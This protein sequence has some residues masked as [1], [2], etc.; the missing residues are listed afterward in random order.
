[1]VSRRGEL[2][3]RGIGDETSGVEMLVI[4]MIFSLEGS[5]ISAWNDSRSKASS[6]PWPKRREANPKMGDA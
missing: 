6:C 1:M 2:F 4:S 5:T 3:R